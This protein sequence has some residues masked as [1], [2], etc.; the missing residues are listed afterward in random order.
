MS[1]VEMKLKGRDSV[2]AYPTDGG[3]ICL[4][5]EDP[6]GG[7]PSKILLLPSDVPVVVAWLQK[8]AEDIK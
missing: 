6:S 4:E 7:D 1:I 3:Y 5:Q 8:L 2:E